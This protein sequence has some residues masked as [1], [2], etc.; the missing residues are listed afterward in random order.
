[1]P[2]DDA[3]NVLAVHFEAVDGA[4]LAG[5]LAVP[6]AVRAAAIVC[7]PHPLYGG[8]RNNTVVVTVADALV[9]RGIATV[10]FDFR[11][12]YDHGR[13]ERLDAEAALSLLADEFTD[14]PL[15]AVGYSFGAIVT[16]SLADARVAAQVL[17]APPL[18][19]G[20]PLE[21][22]RTATLVLV[23][24]HDQFAPP[25]VAGPIVERWGADAGGTTVEWQPIASADHSI[26]GR[27]GW[28]AERAAHWL[29]DQ[30]D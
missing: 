12:E 16:A 3:V 4:R 23:P 27:A 7:H 24:A 29:A 13:G 26:T 11:A 30:L 15:L 19:V 20:A 28:V 5:E 10:R 9:E 21:P 14:M 1:M 8:D 22:P 17:I 6:P 2:F 25:D 18:G